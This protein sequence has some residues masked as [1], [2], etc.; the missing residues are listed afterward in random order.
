MI[1]LETSGVS[2][3]SQFDFIVQDY[4]SLSEEN[5]PVYLESDIKLLILGAKDWELKFCEQVCNLTAEYKDITYLFNFT[6][7]RQFQQ[8]MKS[9]ERKCC[10][11]IPYEPNPF[12]KT[13]QTEGRDFFHEILR[14]ILPGKNKCIQSLR[15]Q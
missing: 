7:G 10:Y 8:I 14:P 12:A 4:G 3:L 1:S 11:R 2:D 13:T 5:L 6:N 9:M 15:G